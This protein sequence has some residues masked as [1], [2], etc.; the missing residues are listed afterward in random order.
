MDEAALLGVFAPCLSVSHHL[1]RDWARGRSLRLFSTLRLLGL[2]VG[3]LHGK[4]KRTGGCDSV[5]RVAY[6]QGTV[7]NF[8]CCLCAPFST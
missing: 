4:A 5:V 7:K 3:A 1:Y 8:P 6:I 2:Q